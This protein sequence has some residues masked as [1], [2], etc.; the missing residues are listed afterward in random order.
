MKKF[1]LTGLNVSFA[2][3]VGVGLTLLPISEGWA[4]YDQ[5]VCK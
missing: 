3:V 4:R 5:K 1:S 2:I